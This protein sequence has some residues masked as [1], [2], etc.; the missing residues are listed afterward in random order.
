MVRG[1]TTMMVQA[2]TIGEIMN[3]ADLPC[4]VGMTTNKSSM[5]LRTNI[6]TKLV[7]CKSTVHGPVDE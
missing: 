6:T 5:F 4:L 2:V 7:P 1:T 3:T